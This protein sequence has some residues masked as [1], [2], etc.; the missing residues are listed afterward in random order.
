[1]RVKSLD[2]VPISYQV[3]G[4]GEPALVFVHGWCCDKSYWEPQVTHFAQKY[5]V[6]TIDLAGHGESGQERNRW[7]MAAFGEDV[8]AVV[9][10]LA[11]EQVVLIGHSMG[12]H[13]IVEAAQRIPD[14]VLGIVGVD[15]FGNVNE[16]VAPA[17]TDELKAKALLNFAGVAR[18]AAMS[19]FVKTSDP[20]LVERIVSDMSSAPPV[21]AMGSAE[22][23]LYHKLTE[24]L[25][26]IKVPIHCICSDF[27]PFDL[28]AVQR[29]C[30]SF[31]VTFMSGVG[32]FVMLEDPVSF[33]NLLE[34]TI[35]ELITKQL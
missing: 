18:Q 19:M 26:K 16:K 33:N 25:E 14:G 11:L 20:V 34:K 13:V 7:T 12:G 35:Q 30:S 1:M 10:Q 32:H 21:V 31:K 29:H 27:R 9:N 24:A 8:A 22:E 5:R 23:R 17:S 6:V 4:T 2:G 28:E 3:T 15:T